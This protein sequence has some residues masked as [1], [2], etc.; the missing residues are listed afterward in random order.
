MLNHPRI[1][2]RLLQVVLQVLLPLGRRYLSPR[3]PLSAWTAAVPLL[4]G[5]P[6][7]ALSA[8]MREAT[9]SETEEA[10]SSV[11]YNLAEGNGRTG[12]D[13]RHLF[14][15]AY[16]SCRGVQAI[17]DVAEAWGWLDADDTSLWALDLTNGL[18]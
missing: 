5:P 10:S 3:R 18:Q 13:R 6:E 8:V 14:R 7:P 12:G 2:H 15:I 4:A 9:A 16:S 17:L 11:A 1:C